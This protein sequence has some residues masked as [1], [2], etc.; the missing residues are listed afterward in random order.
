MG[1]L[2][3]LFFLLL[4]FAAA[5][6]APQQK[7]VVKTRGRLVNG[8]VVRGQGIPNAIIQLEERDVQ[9]QAKDG[10]TKKGYQLLDQQSCREYAYSRDTL[11]LVMEA[12]VPLLRDSLRMPC[13]EDEIILIAE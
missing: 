1:R 12:T 11:Y 2:L 8:K 4:S 13:S 3:S 6:Q 9:S 10:V 5:A 7:G